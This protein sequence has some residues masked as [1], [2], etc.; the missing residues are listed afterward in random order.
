MDIDMTERYPMHTDFFR[1]VVCGE[2]KVKI[3]EA[4][5][6]CEGCDHRYSVLDG[7]PLL[8]RDWEKLRD[9]IGQ[10]E[11]EKPGWYTDAQLPEEANPYHYHL[12][13]RRQYVETILK[14]HIARQDGQ[15]FQN[16][17]DLGCGD[18]NH[19]TYLHAYAQNVYGSDYN[20]TRLVRAQ[21]RWPEATLFLA[22][23]LDYPCCEA[24]FDVIFF[25][26]VI[27]HIPD[28]S[29]ALKN[30][31]RILKPGGLLVLGTPNEGAAWWQLAYRLQPKLLE[32]SDHVHFYTAYSLTKLIS[33]QGFSIYDKKYLGWGVPHWG[34]DARLRRFCFLDDAFE[35]IGRIL[36]PNQASSLYVLATRP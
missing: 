30:I 11:K 12:K 27:E 15:L 19:L 28:D 20:L 8:V 10:A 23:I 25:N 17:L 21:E 24:F 13:K 33:D 32:T 14:E 5:W 6:C 16:L 26:H 36:F 22:D 34:L 3:L 18:G 2:E 7:I 29:L 1:C 31:Y 35:I 4:A 9:D